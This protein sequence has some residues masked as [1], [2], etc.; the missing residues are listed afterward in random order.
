MTMD[1]ERIDTPVIGVLTLVDSRAD[2][3]CA[4]AYLCHYANGTIGNAFVATAVKL[5]ST[6]VIARG[7]YVTV[8]G[9]EYPSG[10]CDLPGGLRL[11]YRFGLITETGPPRLMG[12]ATVQI[13]AFGNF[14]TGAIIG[15]E[16]RLLPLVSRVSRSGCLPRRL[17]IP[18][19]C[20]GT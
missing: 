7:P 9:T 5:G 18:Q 13:R 19:D 3:L 11:D 14:T 15:E 10:D 6:V 16:A 20:A 4:Q 2:D 17:D 12:R 8:N 1:D